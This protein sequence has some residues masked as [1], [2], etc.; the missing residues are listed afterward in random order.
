MKCLL[1][2]FAQDE[3]VFVWFFVGVFIMKCRFFHLRIRFPL[4]LLFICM[5]VSSFFREMLFRSWFGVWLCLYFVQIGTPSL[6]FI[7][8]G[9][10]DP[11]DD[12]FSLWYLNLTL[13]SNVDPREENGSERKVR[14]IYIVQTIKNQTKTISSCAKNFKRHFF[15]NRLKS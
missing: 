11:F 10:F 14:F 1:K 2:F 5:F 15:D 7:L 12:C 9:S 13:V 6:A 3:M 8:S 4:S